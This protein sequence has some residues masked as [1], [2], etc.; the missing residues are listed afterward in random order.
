MKKITIRLILVLLSSIA[1]GA[2]AKIATPAPINPADAG[3]LAPLAT[4]DIPAVAARA[5]QIQSALLANPPVLKLA[6][7]LDDLQLA[8]QDL[9]LQDSRFQ[10]VY[11][12][13]ATHQVLRSEV[14][15][16]Y[17]TRASDLTPA[18][19]ACG[20][21]KCYRVELY[22]YALNVTLIAIVD[23]NA[24]AVLAVNQ[25]PETQPDLPK[26]LAELAVQI[27]THA[28]EVTQALGH[29]PDPTA[30]M[31]AETKTAL[32][33]TL[34]ERSRHLCVAPT[35]V[36]G[37]RALW[38]IVDLTDDRLIGVRWTDLGASS[39]HAVTE[40]G[41]ENEVVAAQSCL[42]TTALARGGWT[43]NYILTSSDGLRIS[44][45][46][47]HDQPVLDSAK[48]VDWH[49]SYSG[50]DGFGYSDAAGCPVFSQAAVI[51]YGPP[52]VED[53]QQNSQSAGFVLRQKF[54][55]EEWPLPCNYNYEQRYEFYNDGSFRIVGGSLGRGC[56]N[57]GTY[58][59]VLRIALA[60]SYTF[61]QWSG[62]AWQAWAT[63]QWSLQ[64]PDTA[65]TPEGYLYRLTGP[66][67]AGYYVEPNRGQFGD[68]SRGDNAYVY[69]TL[70]KPNVDEGDSDLVTLGGCCNTDYHQ[71]PEKF[72]EPA[73]DPI[74]AS[75][76]VIW[77]V[78]QLKND[79]TPGHEYCWADS[80]LAAGVYTAKVWPCYAGPLFVPIAK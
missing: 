78:P 54:Q 50:A 58:R 79:D 6:D 73:P 14:F 24:R 43:L 10:Q 41:L 57:N 8:A 19:A 39:G 3:V 46:R 60:G 67:G 52:Q 12:D 30:A 59:P 70:H 37:S 56:G 45:V 51:A 76:L 25:I 75:P 33:H 13:P 23:V 2:C 69:A 42:T 38:A 68:G 49:V 11:H 20:Q 48:L 77:Y 71:G 80:V 1:L 31:M 9:A 40:K 17:P 61:S 72:I 74:L 62:T 18:T 5:A 53:L 36:Q 26:S 21:S 34:C 66:A 64:Q 29:Q 27:A 15:G 44:E 35:F 65:Y 16:I 47:F 22:N 63:E 32:N 7:G 28:P 55:S 4:P